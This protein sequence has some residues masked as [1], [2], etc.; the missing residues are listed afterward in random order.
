MARAARA[1]LLSSWCMD[2]T[3]LG[4]AGWLIEAAGLRLVCDPLVEVDHHG[5]VFEVCPRRRLRA[6]ALRADF[7]LISHRHPDHFDVRSLAQL[8]AL[9]PDSVVITPDELVAATARALGFRS[10]R[11][12]AAGQLVELERLR[13]VTS[14]SLSSDEWGVMIGSDEGVVWNQVD[15]VFR[16]LDHLRGVLRSGLAALGATRIDLVLATWQPMLEIAAQLGHAIEFPHSAYAGLLAQ[17]AAIEP[18]AIVPASAGTIHAAPYAWLNQVVCPV[19]EAR[20]LADAARA[21]PNAQVLALELGARYRVRAGA[22]VEVDADAG[23]ALIERL[24]PG[25]EPE[26]RPFA[27][28]ALHDP[29]EFLGAPESV[30][31]MHAQVLEWIEG[32]LARA[33]VAHFDEFEVDRPLRFVVEVVFGDRTLARTLVVDAQTC[34]SVAG[35]DP[36]WDV[37]DA[38]AGTMLWEVVVGR[39]HWGDLLLSGGLRARSRAYRVDAAG[40]HRARVGETFLYYALSYAD[41]VARS[42]AWEVEQALARRA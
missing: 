17:L 19:D 39:R 10:V 12:V 25:P 18:G 37:Y 41:S 36:S 7:I 14:A 22:K 9:D 6:A 29:G 32:S 21:C 16:D 20:F 8:A 15:T 4:H 3:S 27:I 31:V 35:C 38:A 30:E 24:E 11:V 28:P 2:W 34:T 26:F 33:L 23:A 42:V 1:G 13:F 5:G 40:L